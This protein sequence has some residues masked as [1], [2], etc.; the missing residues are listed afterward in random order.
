M[1]NI[2]SFT[3]SIG[4]LKFMKNSQQ[5]VRSSNYRIQ[6]IFTCEMAKNFFNISSK[7]KSIT[8]LAS[9]TITDYIGAIT[10]TGFPSINLL[11]NDEHMIILDKPANMLSVPGKPGNP[12]EYQY[13]MNTINSNNL[14][15]RKKKRFEEWI[16][17]IKEAKSHCEKNNVSNEI[18]LTMDQILQHESIPRKKRLFDSFVYRNCKLPRNERST[19]LIDTVWNHIVTSDSKLNRQ[20]I[21]CIPFEYVGVTHLAEKYFG[22]RLFSV[23]RLDKETSGLLILAKTDIASS[24]L[25]K[26]F[27]LR[28]ISKK[29]VAKVQGIVERE[30]SEILIPMRPDLHNKPKSI[31][32]MIHGKDTITLVKVLETNKS[33]N[34]SLVQLSPITGRTHQL[35][36]VMDHIGHPIIGDS[37]YGNEQSKSSA[38]RMCLHAYQVKLRHPV[39]MNEIIIQIPYPKVFEE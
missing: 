14:K 36:V 18:I 2:S 11:Y 17:A 23:H 29:Y 6:Q 9:Q 27:R 3:S 4:F 33:K 35:R 12:I 16:D 30:F 7:N 25:C 8:T 22:Q 39:K 24:D 37:I 15:D 32:D 13:F 34:T 28:K 5:F 1:L 10:I 19:V 21:D 26:Q 20:S 31:V 38:S